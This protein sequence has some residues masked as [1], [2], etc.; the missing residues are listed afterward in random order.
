MHLPV[1]AIDRAQRGG[2]RREGLNHMEISLYV[3][4]AVMALLL[5]YWMSKVAKRKPGTPLTG[6]FAYRETLT[7]DPPAATKNDPRRRPLPGGPRR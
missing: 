4:D 6:L 3:F 1:S 5:F 7:S 2:N